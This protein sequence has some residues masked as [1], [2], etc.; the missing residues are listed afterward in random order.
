MRLNWKI[1]YGGQ[2][3]YSDADGSPY[4]APRLNVQAIVGPDRNTGR[5]MVSDK[6][7]YWWIPEEQRWRGGDRHGEWIYMLRLGPRVVLYGEQIDEDEYNSCIS[8]ALNDPDFPP[9]TARGRGELD[10]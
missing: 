1:F 5:Y 8:A 9:K 4:D 10:R 7:A 2:V 6:D 3:T